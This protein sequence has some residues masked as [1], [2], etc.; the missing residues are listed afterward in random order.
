MKRKIMAFMSVAALSIATLGVSEVPI[1]AYDIGAS[2]NTA[3][4]VNVR[5]GRTKTIYS[6]IDYSGDCDCF[7]F[8]APITGSYDIWTVSDFDTYGRLTGPDVNVTDDDSGSGLNFDIYV[9]ELSVGY[10]YYVYVRAYGDETGDYKL[11][12][13]SYE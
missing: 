6:S 5:P 3:E 2:Q 7:T 11:K 13:A 1:K 9:D 10:K 8:W 12:I 4:E